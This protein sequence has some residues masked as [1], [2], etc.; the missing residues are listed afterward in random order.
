[1][2]LWQLAAQA[3]WAGAR[4]LPPASMRE[5]GRTVSRCGGRDCAQRRTV[6]ASALGLC[7]VLAIPMGVRGQNSPPDIY[8]GAPYFDD[9]SATTQNILPISGTEGPPPQSH[10]IDSDDDVDWG[11]C[12][13]RPSESRQW[14]LVISN[15]VIPSGS[16]ILV[17][18]YENGPQSP[19][20]KTLAVLPGQE[21]GSLTWLQDPF[22][23]QIFFSVRA[24]GSSGPAMSYGISL[25]SSQ[26]ATLPVN[27]VEERT[28]F[29]A[30]AGGSTAARFAATQEPAEITP[31]EGGLY[32][33]H[34]VEFPG[35]VL[36][37]EADPGRIEVTMRSATLFERA[38]PGPGR[39]FPTQSGA[40]WVIATHDALGQPIAFNDPVNITVQFMERPE[41]WLTDVVTLDTLLGQPPQM[42]LACDTIAGSGVDFH[43]LGDGNES[44]DPSAGLVTLEGLVGLT[45]SD[46]TGTWGAAVDPTVAVG[47]GFDDLIAHLVGTAPISEQDQSQ[48]DYNGDGILDTGDVVTAINASNETP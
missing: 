34:R 13:Q 27:P 46:G 32:C 4:L 10:T 36:T 37:G 15:P 6:W 16:R 48:V 47:L 8:E 28:I 11:I 38:T 26:Q 17:E 7:L 44:V 2:G 24:Q 45:G 39:S 42:R 3:L 23:D 29:I 43:L 18:L 14:K 19:A 21:E 25:P 5:A 40:L 20:T 9:T 41:Y 30:P 35:Y 12:P 33:L 22:L 31:G 1:M